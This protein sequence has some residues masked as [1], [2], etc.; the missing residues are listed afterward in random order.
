MQQVLQ[1]GEQSNENNFIGVNKLVTFGKTFTMPTPEREEEVREALAKQ[2][3]AVEREI[4]QK[5]LEYY[6]SAESGVNQKFFDMT[7]ESYVA[8]NQ[9]ERRNLDVVKN[10]VKNPRNQL[11]LMYG[12]NGTGK[13]L[14]G[15]TIIRE[16]GGRYITSFRLCVEFESASDFK[17]KRNKLE[18][19]D[20]YSSQPCVV[21]D[22]VGRSNKE[23][24]EKELLS[25]IIDQRYEN[26]LPT[27]V[28]S[29]L[30]KQSIIAL[31]GV[32]VYDRL[33][34]ICTA[35][36]FTGDSYRKEQ[37]NIIDF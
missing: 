32:A 22:E 17:A 12:K 10:F 9:E 3:E 16:L 19:L 36:D 30:T 23:A 35:L 7:V 15:S 26:N 14:L 11:L 2:Q 5:R 1:S 28:I 8:H 4:K 33:T 31:L 37:R 27:V 29:N 6:R 20:D 18:V 25:Y 34:E 21:I 13:T 24:T